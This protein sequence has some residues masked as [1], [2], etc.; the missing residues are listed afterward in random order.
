MPEQPL[1]VADNVINTYWL[2]NLLP[3]IYKLVPVFVVKVSRPYFSTGLQG[4]RE[5]FGLGT[6]LLISL[7][8]VAHMH[9][10]EDRVCDKFNK[11]CLSPT[12]SRS[13]MLQCKGITNNLWLPQIPNESI[14]YEPCLLFS[15]TV[16]SAAMWS[17]YE[18]VSKTFDSTRNYRI[19]VM[20]TRYM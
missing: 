2:P 12:L 19:I 18:Y 16:F 14:K 3:T 8:C 13:C 20:S 15:S 6:R 7:K 9:L 4:A 17:K 11:V 5:K 10:V 1:L